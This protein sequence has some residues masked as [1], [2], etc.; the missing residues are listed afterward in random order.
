VPDAA[1][2]VSYTVFVAH[3]NYQ[4]GSFAMVFK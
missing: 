2:K 4:K 3:Q 1:D